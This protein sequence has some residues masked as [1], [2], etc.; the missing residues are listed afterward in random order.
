MIIFGV[1]FF[2]N[3]ERK[4]PLRYSICAVGRKEN[5]SPANYR[6]SQAVL[7]CAA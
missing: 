7:L 3:I 4:S 6:I 1:L 2:M 5:I